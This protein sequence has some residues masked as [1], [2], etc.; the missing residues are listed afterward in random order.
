MEFKGTVVLIALVVLIIILTWVGSTIRAGL[1]SSIYPPVL[2]PCPDNWVSDASGNCL[3]PDLSGN[4]PNVGN[5]IDFSATNPTTFGY[6]A[7]N[8]LIDFTNPGWAS[9]GTSAQCGQRAWARANEIYW[10]TITNYNQC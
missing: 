9:G 6:D 1:K 3:I 2:N 8:R 7:T 10:D 4:N 5:V